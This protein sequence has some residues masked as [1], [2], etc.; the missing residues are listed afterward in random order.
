MPVQKAEAGFD[1]ATSI[2]K[3]M[4][5]PEVTTNGRD[6]PDG[7]P[8]PTSETG[9]VIDT[10]QDPQGIAGAIAYDFTIQRRV[11][12]IYRPWEAC[13]RCTN[14]I[15]QGNVT[16]PDDEGD[17]ECPH[18]TLKAYREIINKVLAAEYVSGGEQ[19]VVQKDG[20]I[21]ISLRWYEKKLN[22]K[23]ARRLAKENEGGT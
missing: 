16:L 6:L 8:L 2:S 1:F 18:T 14:A 20:S 7:F 12:V 19:E 10:A 15:A 17:Y 21:V 13:E 22:H 11:F 4:T 9:R 3:A 23:R 5:S